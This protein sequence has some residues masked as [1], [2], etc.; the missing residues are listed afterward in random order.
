[1][2]DGNEDKEQRLVLLNHKLTTF[3]ACHERH[4]YGNMITY[5]VVTSPEL[6]RDEYIKVKSR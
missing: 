5:I 3:Y 4:V 1:M 2:N 6:T